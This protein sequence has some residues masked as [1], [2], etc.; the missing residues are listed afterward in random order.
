MREKFIKI[1]KTSVDKLPFST[2][3]QLIYR[4]T[5]TNGFGLLVGK[6]TKSYF[7]ERKVSSKTRRVMVGRHGEISTEQARREDEAL[8]GVMGQ[9]S[10]PVEEKKQEKA[11]TVTLNE[12]FLEFLNKRKDLKTRTIYYY[13]RTLET[14]FKDWLDKPIVDVSKDMISERHLKIGNENGEAKA[15]LAMRILRAVMNFAA[16]NY[17]DSDGKPI[18]TENPVKRLSQTR[19]WYRVKIRESLIKKHELPALFDALDKLELGLSNSK[20]ETVRDYILFLLFTG[21]RRQEAATLK[22]GDIDFKDK[23]LTIK[24]T[25]NRKTHTLPLSDFLF[26]LLK[27]QE[28]KRTNE[29]VF[30]GRS[31]KGYLVEPKRQL[32]KIRELSGL[33]FMLHDL[34]RTFATFA[35]SLDISFYAVKQMLNHKM[36]GE[37]T[38]GYIIGD[39]ERLRKPMQQITDHILKNAKGKKDA[40]VIDLDSMR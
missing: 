19:A 8:R 32:V 21:L 29:Y 5:Q 24:E 13:K 1:T 31:A 40:D 4:D 12:V 16:G 10:D 18:I 7:V 38:A 9:G 15:N 26:D 25:K 33:K 2:S 17:D 39:V 3:G 30:P 14:Y 22:W 11:N 28:K 37:T 35:A 20:A 27:K 36:R 34:R 23:T 6:R